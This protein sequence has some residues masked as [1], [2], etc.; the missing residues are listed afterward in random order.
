MRSTATHSIREKGP[1][2][3]NLSDKVFSSKDRANVKKLQ[4]LVTKDGKY[5]QFPRIL[6]PN[7]SM[8]KPELFRSEVLAK[9]QLHFYIFND[10]NDMNLR[11]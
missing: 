7:D 1:A 10:F 5:V 4:D 11:Y 2:I 9:V 8:K 6:Y 3:F